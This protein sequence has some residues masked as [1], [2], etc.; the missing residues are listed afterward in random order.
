MALRSQTGDS[1]TISPRTWSM[2]PL[3]CRRGWPTPLWTP[4]WR[5]SGAI[6]GTQMA[7]HLWKADISGAFK[8]LP[9]HWRHRKY[10][11]SIWMDDMHLLW[12]PQHC[13]MAFGGRGSVVAWFRVGALLE[14]VL[15]AAATSTARY[16]DDYF[17]TA[18]NATHHTFMM[19]K[20]LTA[21]VGTRVDVDKCFSHVMS[22]VVLGARV[23]IDLGRRT[24]MHRLCEAK[25][26]KWS[27]LLDAVLAG[28][29]LPAR[30]ASRW[31]GRFSWAATVTYCK[32]ARAFLRP[33][34]RQAHAPLA[35]GR[36]S[37][38][39]RNSLSWLQRSLRVQAEWRHP[40]ALRLPLIA[41]TDA[42]STTK[43]LAVV[44]YFDGEFQ[45][46]HV[47]CPDRVLELFHGRDDGYIGCLELL[48]F[49]VLL[50]TWPTFLRTSLLICY[51]DN[52][53]VLH[54]LLQ[55]VLRAADCN[56]VVGGAWLMMAELNVAVDLRRVESAANIADL[57]SLARR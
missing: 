36:I 31:A 22:I 40:H 13:T 8:T 6:L 18:R 49:C 29:V 10:V 33:V 37:G 17:G 1:L 38:W 48:A 45:W 43:L 11:V 23:C 19:L 57:P 15:L 21:L 25:A 3:L 28:V 42:A 12:A 53:G 4:S 24:V 50:G 5:S 51:L 14:W 56:Q 55:G 30:E 46:T 16:V 32:A 7:F 54:G 2:L 9:L 35:H 47:A 44:V 39:L 20:V 34:H 27:K 52:Q 26:A 41:W